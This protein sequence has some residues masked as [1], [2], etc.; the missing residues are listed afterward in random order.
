MAA[1]NRHS[2]LSEVRRSAPDASQLRVGLAAA[3]LA[4]EKPALAKLALDNLKVAL[5]TRTTTLSPGTRRP[6]PIAIM[7]N[8]PM[9]DLST[10]EQYYDV[11]ASRKRPFA[12]RAPRGLRRARPTGSAPTTSWR[13][14]VRRPETPDI[15]R[16]YETGMENRRAR[17][18]RRRSAC[19]HRHLS[20]GC[21]VSCPSQR[22]Q[23]HAYL[24][25]HPEI[26]V[27]MEQKAQAHQDRPTRPQV[28]PPS[29][30]SA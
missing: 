8:Q 7:N 15:W 4:T 25:A 21:S 27:E 24:M 6:R 22:R 26:L 20:A 29:T 18:S 3:Q 23:I 10:A 13:W 28:R 12:T 11:G 17:R 9:A 2:R 30:G 19:G 5:R 16:T 1:R 14:R